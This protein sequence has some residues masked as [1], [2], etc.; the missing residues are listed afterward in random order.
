MPLQIQNRGVR[1][2]VIQ[3]DAAVVKVRQTVRTSKRHPKTGKKTIIS[4]RRVIGGSL[5]ILAGETVDKLPNQKPIP[6]SVGRLEQVR[7]N[8]GLRVSEISEADWNAKHRKRPEAPAPRPRSR[9][10]A[11]EE[12]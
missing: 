3:L 12:S 6:A 9:K 10:K 11:A 8:G 1:A 2:A 7:K 5:T 4:K